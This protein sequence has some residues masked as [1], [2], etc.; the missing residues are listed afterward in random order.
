MKFAALNNSAEVGPLKKYTYTSGWAMGY[1]LY[2]YETSWVAF[3]MEPGIY[4]AAIVSASVLLGKA[5]S[6]TALPNQKLLQSYFSQHTYFFGPITVSSSVCGW[7]VP[8]GVTSST[9]LTR[10]RILWNVLDRLHV[11][12]RSTYH[13]WKGGVTG[14][15][16]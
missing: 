9:C 6:T 10:T 7:T 5:G 1:T 2:L 3:F 12:F 15:I 13:K 8:T 11:V 14:L 4:L 16:I